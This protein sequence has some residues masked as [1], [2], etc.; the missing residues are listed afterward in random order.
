MEFDR[1]NIQKR[2]RT[3]ILSNGHIWWTK[4]IV[5]HKVLAF[6]D[7]LVERTK[8]WKVSEQSKLEVRMIGN[9]G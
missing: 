2:L 6:T 8:I 4:D 1:P 9:V 3:K 5:M 7:G